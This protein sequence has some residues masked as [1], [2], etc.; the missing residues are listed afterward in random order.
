IENDE[1]LNFLGLPER[2]GSYRYSINEIFAS[3]KLGELQETVQRIRGMDEKSRKLFDIK[4]L[5]LADRLEVYL[6]VTTLE[7]PL[8]VDPPSPG[9]KP[10]SLRGALTRAAQTGEDNPQAEA[11][12]KI[13]FAYTKGD[14]GGFNRA[15]A[16]YNAK[17]AAEH[18]EQASKADFEAF[19]NNFEPF[20]N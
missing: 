4:L 7:T 9:E 6:G 18:P 19:F 5:E 17:Q 15:V 20:W 16:D 12:G 3:D 1:V 2:P 10:E 11:L 8:M 13:F 14:V